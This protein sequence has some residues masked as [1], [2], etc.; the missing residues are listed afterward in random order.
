MT[1]DYLKAWLYHEHGGGGEM[2]FF[3]QG[4]FFPDHK[5]NLSM[6][7]ELYLIYIPTRNNMKVF[8]FIEDD[9]SI[10]QG[11]FWFALVWLAQA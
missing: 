3:F 10:S 5:F 11:Y 9:R 1:L 7:L 6:K 8:P 2:D 4:F